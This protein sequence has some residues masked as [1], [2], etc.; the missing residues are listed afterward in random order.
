VPVDPK[1]VPIIPVQPVFRTEPHKP[2]VI[3]EDTNHGS[4]GKA[5]LGGDAIKSEMLTR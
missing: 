2:L 5:L 1:I 4:L 3:L